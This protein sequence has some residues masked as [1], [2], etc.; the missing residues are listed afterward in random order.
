MGGKIVILLC[1]FLT[2]LIAPSHIDAQPPLFSPAEIPAPAPPLANVTVIRQRYVTIDVEQL[3]KQ[4]VRGVLLNLFPN[5][6]YRAVLD[7][8]DYVGNSLVWVGHIADSTSSSVTLS[9][10][11]RAVYG[12]IAIDASVYIVRVV[13][14]D[15]HA[16]VQ[17]DPA[18]F[19]PERSPL[20]K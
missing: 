4:D 17:I 13:Q 16:I 9:L 8:I 3:R 6:S 7:R 1:F 10:E 15:V 14:D 11:N 18:A 20:Q 5:A 2:G 19:P 12:R